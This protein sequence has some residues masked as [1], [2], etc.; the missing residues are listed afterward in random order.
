MNQKVIFCKC[1]IAAIILL[2]FA[3]ISLGIFVGI[4]CLDLSGGV[5]LFNLVVDIVVGVFTIWGLYWAASQFAE[6]AIRPSLQLLPG[7]IDAPQVFDGVARSSLVSNPP[8]RVNGWFKKPVMGGP[9]LDYPHVHCGLYLSN[10][11][12]K[13]GQYIHLRMHV[14]ASPAPITCE[15]QHRSVAPNLTPS[16]IRTEKE[17]GNDCLNLSVRLSDEL[18]VYQVPVFIGDLIVRWETQLTDAEV[19]RKLLIDYDVYTLDGA[20]QGKLDLYIDWKKSAC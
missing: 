14:C 6:F 15:F 3:F 13:A 19:P 20:S 9:P 11:K 16:R 1:V 8:F 7:K 5:S 17:P 4:D 10:R 2:F 18:V 12:S